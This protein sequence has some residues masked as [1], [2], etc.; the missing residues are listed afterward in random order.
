MRVLLDHQAFDLQRWGGVSRLFLELVRGL[1]R[2]VEVELAAVRCRSEYRPELERLLG[3]AL[4]EAGYRDTF[5]GGRKVPLAKQLWSIRKR[6]SPGT[7]AARLNHAH[8]LERLRAGGHDLFHPT[9]FDPYFLEHLR[10]RPFVLTVHDLTHDVMPELLPTRDDVAA[11]RRL[12]AARAARIIA[13][14]EHTRRDVIERLGV[15]PAKVDVVHHGF[16]WAAPPAP[17]PPLPE[18][19]L[20]YTGTRFAYKN[21]AFFVE[22]IAPLL[23]DVPDLHLV[24]VGAPFSAE[25]RAHV[26]R[27][28]L[29]DRVVPAVVRE[30]ALRA[31]YAG[32]VA[33]AYPS[34]YEGFGIPVLEAFA[35]GCPAVLARASSLPEV[36]GEAALYFDPRDAA[37]IRDALARLLGDPALRAELVARG[38]AR[39][40]EFTWERA[41]AATA[42]TYRRALGEAPSRPGAADRGAGGSAA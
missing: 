15:D 26:G 42:E 36:G 11:R 29:A 30:G 27:L 6:L 17:P 10:G 12:L 16:G 39:V 34:L 33:F 38:R 35:E 19:Y 9:Y 4:P 37:S 41:C 14:S 22:A 5:L 28:G 20:L 32:A 7:L 3:R 1:P 23:R 40:A 2:H 18:R 21:W 31:V 13:V 8:A 24:C 25:E